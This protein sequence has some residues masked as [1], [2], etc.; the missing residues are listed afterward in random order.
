M[1]GILLDNSI[2]ISSEEL[3][4]I[5]QNKIS[6][7]ENRIN[8]ISLNYKTENKLMQAMIENG[9]RRRIEVIQAV[10]ECCIGNSIDLEIL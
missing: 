10:I 9:Y 8:K 1:A 4:I 6:T 2:K 3:V 7:I 5:L